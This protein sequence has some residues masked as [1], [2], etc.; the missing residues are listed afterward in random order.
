MAVVIGKSD[1]IHDYL[2]P[3]SL[4]PDEHF[5]RGKLNFATG[6]VANAATDNTGSKYLL[7]KVPSDAILDERTALQVQ[8]WGFAQVQIGTVSAATA[9][10]D[11]TKAAANVQN[12][13]AFGDANHGKRLWER[14]G[15]AADPGGEI[16]IY[17]HAAANATGA[18]SL[19]FTIGWRR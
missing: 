19:K 8:N 1:L 6:T 2:N 15:L 5:L 11:V 17:A 18:G 9:I 10:L 16:G 7:C 13:V 12:P 14:L 3:A 4:P